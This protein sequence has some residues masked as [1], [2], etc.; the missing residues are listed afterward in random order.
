MPEP[1]GPAGS[2]MW[3]APADAIVATIGGILVLLVFYPLTLCSAGV[4][5]LVNRFGSAPASSC[6][7]AR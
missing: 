7:T 6:P 2:A 5:K 1:G 3:H 4:K